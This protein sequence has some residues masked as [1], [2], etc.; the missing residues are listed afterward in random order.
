MICGFV[1][2]F[3]LHIVEFLK[4]IL[5]SI[6]RCCDRCCSCDKKQTRQIIQEDYEKVYTGPEFNLQ[7]RYATII[8]LILLVF[9]YSPG[10]PVMYWCLPAFFGVALLI[11][12]FLCT[13]IIT[14]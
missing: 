9:I 7:I 2:V 13:I 5:T 11:D 10:M 1:T 3:T 8:N 6:C 12:K 14:K 4:Y